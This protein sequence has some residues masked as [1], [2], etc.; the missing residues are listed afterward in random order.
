LANELLIGLR[1]AIMSLNKSQ[2]LTVSSI[3]LMFWLNACSAD[4]LRAA[5]NK[6]AYPTI[7]AAITLTSPPH[8]TP[9]TAVGNVSLPIVLGTIISTTQ[10]SHL[11]E[12]LQ[13]EECELPCYLGITP[14]KTSWSSAQQILSDLGEEYQGE[15][16]ESGTGMLGY[17]YKL[18]ISSSISGMVTPSADATPRLDISHTLDFLVGDLIVQRIWASIGTLNQETKFRDYWSRYSPQQIFTRLG[19][20]DAVY[21]HPG[22]GNGMSLVYKSLG[23]V[24]EFDGIREGNAVC[25]NFETNGYAGRELIL[26]NTASTLSLL[27]EDSPIPLTDRSYWLPVTEFLGISREELYNRIIADSSVC[28]DIKVVEP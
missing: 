16:Y 27:P 15:Y 18:L 8:T 20:P 7:K 21:Y 14:G 22:E 17:E 10:E 4:N 26:T 19:V 3:A 1:Q 24:M 9:P 28:F 23:V 11:V 25:P 12:I 13:F 6:T 5:E 2:L